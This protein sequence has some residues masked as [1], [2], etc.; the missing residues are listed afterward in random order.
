MIFMN[1]KQFLKPD[2]RKAVIFI[3]IFLLIFLHNILSSGPTAAC[4]SM[5]CEQINLPWRP[6]PVC[7]ITTSDYINGIFYYSIFSVH[8]IERSFT[9]PPDFII[10]I[11]LSAI[12]FFYWYL[13]SC[14]IVWIYDKSRKRK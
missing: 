6:C 14:L 10:S 3:I 5:T 9:K 11:L 4:A 1:I 12:Q 7:S 2:R 13:I 8:L